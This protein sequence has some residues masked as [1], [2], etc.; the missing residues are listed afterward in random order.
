MQISDSTLKILKNFSAINP[1]ILFTPGSTLRTM[2]PQKTVMAVAKISEEVKKRAAVFDLSKFLSTLALFT[3]PEIE[4][5]D[6]RFVI[7]SE[8]S[9]VVYTYAAEDMI[10]AAP[11]D[12][13][14]LPKIDVS[15]DVAWENIQ[16]VIRAAG[17]LQVPDIQMIIRGGI[18]SLIA[19]DIKDPTSN[20]FVV[21]VANG[22]D[23]KLD[24]DLY[25]KSENLKFIPQD[26]KISLCSKG[27]IHFESPVV[28]Y[29]V[30][31]QSR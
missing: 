31:V 12:D 9:K 21:E 27:M 30:A 16:N 14:D 23:K 2:S 4:F 8:Q 13:I 18:F 10:I 25:V 19:T 22:L 6:K 11:E 7:K 3:E 15:C 1:S 26:Y 24:I 20:D 17:V 29:W 28:Q 5:E